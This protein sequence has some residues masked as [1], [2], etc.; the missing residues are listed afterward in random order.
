ML[1]P[2]TGAGDTSQRLKTPNLWRTLYLYI[3]SIDRCWRA[4]SKHQIFCAHFTVYV[5]SIDR[6]WRYKPTSQNTK[7]TAHTLLCMLPLSTGAG[8][9]GQ[10][11]KTP[12]LHPLT[13]PSLSPHSPFLSLLPSAPKTA[14]SVHAQT[15]TAHCNK[16]THSPNQQT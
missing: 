13:L 1:R 10:S 4:V 2:S 3:T 14:Q 16:L 7:F 9:T 11:L 12:N 5:T 8:D 6:C 15:V